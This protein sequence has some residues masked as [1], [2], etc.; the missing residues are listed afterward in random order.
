[1]VHPNLLFHCEKTCGSKTD[2]HSENLGHGGLFCI[3]FIYYY[4]SVKTDWLLIIHV[5][6]V[7]EEVSE[8]TTED[9]CKQI[10]TTK[11]VGY[12]KQLA[13]SYKK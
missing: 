10:P 4:R 1:V 7:S 12:K 8:M 9:G 3:Y 2:L 6:Q 11:S 13:M 5:I